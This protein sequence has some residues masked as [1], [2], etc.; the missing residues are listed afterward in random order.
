VA[1]RPVV[2]GPWQCGIGPFETG[3]TAI[4]KVQRASVLSERVQ[5]A[6]GDLVGAAREG[7]LAERGC[8]AR[9][10]ARADG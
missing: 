1:V 8:R 4:K 6:L 7:L 2:L 3:G 10:D 5:A 9:R